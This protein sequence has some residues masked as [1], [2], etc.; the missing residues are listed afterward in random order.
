MMIQRRLPKLIDDDQGVGHLRFL[1]STIDQSRFPATQ[2]TGQQC[3]RDRALCR[4]GHRIH[5]AKGPPSG[6]QPLYEAQ[7]CPF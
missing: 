3:D 2:K 4:F 7:Y 6:H 5:P 1:Q